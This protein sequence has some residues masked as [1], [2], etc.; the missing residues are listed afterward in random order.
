M[1]IELHDPC[2][3]EYE[4]L[5][6]EMSRHF[7]RTTYIDDQTRVQLPSAEY[8]WRTIDPP[9]LATVLECAKAAVRRVRPLRP[10]G[11][12][13]SKTSET[14]YEGLSKPTNG[15]LLKE[16]AR[17]GKSRGARRGRVT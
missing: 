15:L 4:K 10:F 8:E 13:V 16:R 2:S 3:S 14:L 5:H 1:R 17:R 6:E 11:I 7:T 9:D 12:R